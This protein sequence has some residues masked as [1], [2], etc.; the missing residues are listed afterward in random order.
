MIYR[1]ATPEVVEIGPF[2]YDEAN[3]FSEPKEWDV[4]TTVP[5]TNGA[6]KQNAIEM[7][8]NVKTT[9]NKELTKDPDFETPIY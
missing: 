2:V 5:G 4:K 3:T 6:S 8:F 9:L 1:G 7:T